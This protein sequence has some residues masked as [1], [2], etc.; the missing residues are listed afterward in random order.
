MQGFQ[1]L[2]HLA[3]WD[4]YEEVSNNGDT[5]E[6]HLPICWEQ[7][8]AKEPPSNKEPPEQEAWTVWWHIL[9][10]TLTE[11]VGLV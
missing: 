7:W 10:E 6:G 11:L 8:E 9:P 3:N 1:T 4:I 5:N 2:E